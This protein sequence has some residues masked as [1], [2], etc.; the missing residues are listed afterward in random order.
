[1]RRTAAFLAALCVAAPAHA[2]TPQQI[3][4]LL[5]NPKLSASFPYVPP[6]L[7]AGLCG[8]GDSQISNG[9]FISWA[10]AQFTETVGSG[11]GYLPQIVSR[12]GNNAYWTPGFNYGLGASS[13]VNGAF[14]INAKR[15][16]T[17]RAS[18]TGKIDNG[19]GS[20]GAILTTTAA[21]VT[22]M[23]PGAVIT[24][25]GVTAGT[26]VGPNG[27]ATS[28]GSTAQA[29][30]TYTGVSPSQL[31]TSTTITA[32]P[33]PAKAITTIVSDDEF[34]LSS[35]GQFSALSDP[36]TTPIVLIGTNDP[37]ASIT[38]TQSLT[39]MGQ[40]ADAFGPVGATINGSFVT[41]ANKV[42]VWAD[43][44]P[45][46]IAFAEGE[47]HALASTVTVTNNGASIFES[48]DCDGNVPIRVA[49]ANYKITAGVPAV[50][51]GTNTL[52]TKVGS[53]PLSGQYTV[54]SAGVYGFN[55]AD[56]ALAPNAQFYYCYFGNVRTGAGLNWLLDQHAFINSSSKTFVGPASGTNFGIPGLLYHRPWIKPAAL[57]NA[58]AGP[59][60][61]TT[62]YNIAGTLVDGLHPATHGTATGGAAIASAVDAILPGTSQFAFPANNNFYLIKGTGLVSV[63]TSTNAPLPP[64]MIAQLTRMTAGGVFQICYQQTC[65]VAG[66]A[67]GNGEGTWT[68]NTLTSSTSAITTPNTGGCILYTAD[69]TD[70]CNSSHAAGAF[71]L[72]AFSA[73]IPNNGFVVAY[74]DAP[75]DASG[76]GQGG[77]MLLNGQ[78]DYETTATG[79][80]AG[81]LTTLSGAS[82][83]TANS[84]ASNSNFIPA[85]WTLTGDT[86]TQT[87]LGA[88][89]LAITCGYGTA[90]DGNPGFFITEYGKVAASSSLLLTQGVSSPNSFINSATPDKMRG[91]ARVTI[92][93]GPGGH[94]YGLNS[95]GVKI[96]TALTTSGSVYNIN[97][98]SSACTNI[99]ARA[100]DNAASY[101]DFDLIDYGNTAL[102]IDMIT[103]IVSSNIDA[104]GANTIAQNLFT[105]NPQPFVSQA[106]DMKIWFENAAWRIVS[107]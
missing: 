28:A 105:V 6:A 12:A 27:T 26:T 86:N 1:M 59:T 70:T 65:Y 64:N 106:I 87:A 10:S 69:A 104:G 49:V 17:G 94:L 36:C 51:N 39:Y 22:G 63:Y 78:F 55:A 25:T 58:L 72:P 2:L 37:G 21:S 92:Q 14:R 60:A 62:G 82:C 8:Y 42:V 84:G 57:W 7:N 34:N 68:G 61:A 19:S 67:N 5:S 41:G 40:I 80:V 77:N 9:G 32:V 18:V 93:A 38:E 89:T 16:D 52:F 53:A 83:N 95:P 66:A 35:T 44:A 23:A 48:D 47:S 13:S 79:G 96:N 103:P 90:P 81:T 107:K 101:T 31:V 33:N 74:G 102:K 88:G 24:G 76:V 50:T 30:G 56:V 29:I 11:N 100:L 20:A 97:C 98:P 4:L 73:V 75:F 85:G 3:A 43:M 46:G 45:R 99:A 15:T 91:Y 54:T 71:T